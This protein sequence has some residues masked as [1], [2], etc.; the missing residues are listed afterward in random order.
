MIKTAKLIL[1]TN[2]L[3]EG[4][5]EIPIFAAAASENDGVNEIIEDASPNNGDGNNDDV[6]DSR[7]SDV[8]SFSDLKGTYVTYVSTLDQLFMDV[9]IAEQSV[10]DE[11]PDNVIIE[12]GVHEFT[13]DAIASN[14]IIEIGLILPANVN[15]SAYYVYGPTLDNAVPHWYKF[16]FDGETGVTF[17]G[18]AIITSPS[19]NKIKRNLVTLK[20]KNGGRGDSSSI[21]DTQIVVKSGINYG[22]S[23]ND[24]GG[25]PSIFFLITIFL[26][27]L[28]MRAFL[29]GRG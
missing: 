2:D 15:P 1:E 9:L 10:F 12:T 8:V 4:L 11:N 13:L 22:Y 7:Q 20:I 24:G 17:L 29:L 14:V 6:L 3:D 16:D 5:F 28:L 27:G 26:T 21:A 25:L 19:G 18:T 23:S